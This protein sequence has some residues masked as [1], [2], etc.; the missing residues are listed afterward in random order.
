MYLMEKSFKEKVL[1][2]V[3]K[4]QRGKTAT[5]KQ[6]AARVGSPRAWRA[7]GNLL[8]K[9]YDPK[10]PCHRVVKNDRTIG[11][12][13]RGW[14]E[15]IVKLLQEGAVGVM[16][17]D[18]IYGILGRAQDPK[19]VNRI[20]K[21]KK[22]SSA[23]PF[24]ILISEIDEVKLFGVKLSPKQRKFLK[25]L[26]PGKV[27]VVLPRKKSGIAFR[28]PKNKNLLQILR[29]TGPLVAPSANPEGLPPAI[30]MASARRYFG[31]KVD[32]YVPGGKL[33]SK[34]SKLVKFS[35]GGLITLRA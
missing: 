5:Y 13:N 25:K 8:N 24:I 2:V 33:T 4:I 28:I 14:R 18:T 35:G 21:I 15:K 6:I 22:R 1:W 26:W 29:K 30:S 23:K 9:N 11:G 20:F 10:T 17:T 7:A 31:N 27:S 3:K 12:Y 32:F 19:V 34:P 16:P